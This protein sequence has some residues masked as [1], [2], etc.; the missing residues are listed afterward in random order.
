MR[1][2]TDDE[3]PAYWHTI[4]HTF[5]TD[6]REDESDQDRSV[7]EPERSLAVFDGDAVVATTGIF[8]RDLSIPG[9]VVPAAHVTMVSV[10]ATHRRRGLLNRMMRRQLRDVADA[11]REPIAVLWASEEAIYGRYGY[12]P[13]SWQIAIDADTRE[14]RLPTTAPSGRLRLVAP[15]DAVETL[16][17]VYDTVRPRRPGFSSRPGEWWPHRLT[18]IERHRDGASSR[19]CVLH[20][21][22]EGVTGYALYRVKKNWDDTGPNAEVRV[23]ELVAADPAARAELW[24]FLFDL[25]LSRRI[26]AWALPVD[27]P[28]FHWVDNPR[29][30]DRT[31]GSALYVRVVNLPTALAAR[32]Y[33]APVDL[34]FEVTDELLPENAGRWRLTGDAEKAR[35]ERTTEPADLTLG[36]RELGAAYLGGTPLGYL[37][38]A[39]LVEGRPEAIAAASAAFGWHI[40]PHAPEIF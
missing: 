21:T 17:H 29:R 34:V 19:R 8:S 30:L 4:T 31:Y 12:G 28:L 16:S 35:C 40:A 13:A 18:D 23:E 5:H 37:A 33:A 14:V 32:R 26:S 22:A 7:F 20:E 1:P 24:R 3:W 25:D 36:I 10:L 2:I 27:E 39:G 11:G 38:S 15:H 6:V 9:A